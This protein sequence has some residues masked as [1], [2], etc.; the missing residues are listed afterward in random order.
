MLKELNAQV[1]FDLREFV[2]KG[3]F[4][5]KNP[6]II[7]GVDTSHDEKWGYLALALGERLLYESQAHL[8]TVSARQ[9]AA[10]ELLISLGMLAS[11]KITHP[12][13]PKALNDMLVS[14]RKYLNHLGERE[15]KP[16]VFLLESEPQVT[17]SAN[18]QQDGDKK[19]WLVRDSNDPE[20]AQPWYT[21]ARYFAR[22]LVESDPKLLE[23]RDVLAQKVGQLLTKAGIKKRGGKLPHDPST[24]IKAFSNV[25]L[26]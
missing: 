25:S 15:A 22:Q 24:I 1:L 4:V 16:F 2:P 5:R 23:K 10:I 19:P 8:L 11:F 6:L 17:K 7:N 26:G 9:T 12:E 3:H 21:P 14:L 13:R 18:I 20:P